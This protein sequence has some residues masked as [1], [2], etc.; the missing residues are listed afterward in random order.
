MKHQWRQQA[1]VPVL[2]LRAAAA[3][4][5]ID[6]VK[7]KHWAAQTV[8]A[9]VAALCAWQGWWIPFVLVVVPMVFGAVTY[10]LL[11]RLIHRLGTPRNLRTTVASAR[12]ELRAEFERLELPTGVVSSVLFAWRLA[13]GKKPHAEIAAKL[14]EA[15]ANVQAIVDRATGLP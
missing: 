8:L 5:A 6:F 3:Q 7:P 14:P 10:W 2:L 12:E 13:R 9:V 15:M 1:E 11:V 4:V